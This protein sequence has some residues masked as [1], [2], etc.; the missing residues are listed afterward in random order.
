MTLLPKSL[1]RLLTLHHITSANKGY[2]NRL[3]LRI[4]SNYEELSTQILTN[5]TTGRGVLGFRRRKLDFHGGNHASGQ[6]ARSGHGQEDDGPWT[7][8]HIQHDA[9]NDGLKPSVG[10]AVGVQK[11]G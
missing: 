8:G 5:S 4:L 2:C 9:E 11:A 1:D 3:R 10:V 6:N 7:A